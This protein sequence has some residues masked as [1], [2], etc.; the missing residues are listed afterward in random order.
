MSAD[1]DL[2]ASE[3]ITSLA[4]ENTRLRRA[5]ET[6]RSDSQDYMGCHSRIILPLTILATPDTLALERLLIAGDKAALDAATAIFEGA[7]PDLIAL[8]IAKA[9]KRR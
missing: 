3:V 1:N 2:L 6:V 4:E 7:V 5:L 9:K 8:W